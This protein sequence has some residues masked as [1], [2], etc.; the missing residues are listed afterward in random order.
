[1][2]ILWIFFGIITKFDYIKGP[3]LFLGVLEMIL[4]FLG[5]A[6]PEPSYED[7]LFVVFLR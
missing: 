7:P 1:M 2:K 5:G 6:G 4:I 3:F